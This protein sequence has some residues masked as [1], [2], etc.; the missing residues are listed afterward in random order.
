MTASRNKKQSSSSPGSCSASPWFPRSDT[1][2]MRI[3]IKRPGRRDPEA[4]RSL[5]QKHTA[6]PIN[7][8]WP[9][10]RRSRSSLS[11]LPGRARSCSPG[12]VILLSFGWGVLLE[13]VPYPVHLPRILWASQAQN[14]AFRMEAPTSNL[15]QP[16]CWNHSKSGNK[17]TTA[18]LRNKRNL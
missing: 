16:S 6:H 5:T 8:H 2:C 9:W 13:D 11:H 3:H 17:G 14:A 1:T 15:C 7:M 12:A 4:S 10:Y 18:K